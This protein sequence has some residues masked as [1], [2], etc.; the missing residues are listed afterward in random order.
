M[1]K[2][3]PMLFNFSVTEMSFRHKNNNDY[4][5]KT[6]QYSHN[7]VTI[8]SNTEYILLKN[9]DFSSIRLW[10]FLWEIFNQPTN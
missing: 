1:V 2:Q 10:P 7:N 3:L 4:T 9:T 8:T 6:D 5:R